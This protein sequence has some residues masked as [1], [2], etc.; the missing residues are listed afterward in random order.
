MS[1]GV[2]LVVLGRVDSVESAF[3]VD[4]D[5]FRRPGGDAGVEG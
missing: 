1:R 2:Q 4:K 3:A 5:A